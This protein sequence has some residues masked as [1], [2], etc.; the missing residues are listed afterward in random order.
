MKPVIK[1]TNLLCLVSDLSLQCS[2][3]AHF[4]PHEEMGQTEEKKRTYVFL[5]QL[6]VLHDWKV[7]QRLQFD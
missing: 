5:L 6:T 3:M 4:Y 7:L 2:L 1:L